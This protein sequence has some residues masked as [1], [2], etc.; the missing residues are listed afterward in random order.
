VT[1]EA[2]HRRTASGIAVPPFCADPVLDGQGTRRTVEQSAPGQYPFTRGIEPSLYGDGSWVMG[3]YSGYSSPRETNARIKRLVSAGQRGFSVALDLPT[4]L[5]LDSDDPRARGE[6]GRVGV[7]I[8]SLADMDE[9]LAGIPLEQI[10]QIRTTANAIGPIAVALFI[11][12]AEGRGV[13]PAS[14]RLLLQNDSLKE[15]VARGTYIFPPGPSLRFSVD[16]IEYCAKTL[17]SW[18]PIEFCGYHI[19]DTGSTAVQEVAVALSNARG[20]LDEAGRRGV[21]M[22]TLA[23]HLYMFL[24]AG[25]DI[26]EEIAKF[27]AARRVWARMLHTEYGVPASACGLRIFCYTL[28]SALTATEPRN[29]VVRVAYEALAAALGG[30]QTLAT[31]SYDEALGLPSEDAVHLS[32]RTQ[33]ILAYET[34]VCRVTDPLGGSHYVEWLTDELDAQVTSYME[35]IAQRGG[36]LGILES[37]WLANELTQASYQLQKET[38][39]GTRPL[40]GVNTLRS[41]HQEPGDE[42]SAF[43]LRG[44]DAAQEQVARLLRLR[45]ERDNARVDRALAEL[46][47]DAQAGANTVPKVLDA[48]RAYATVGEICATLKSIWGEGTTWA[49]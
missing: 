35:A 9:L 46:R 37:G 18:E 10:A 48:I 14:F 21:D 36:C 13:D 8:D 25:M 28:G 31:S 40:V 16:V 2:G 1:T 19:R 6:V 22:V 38:D 27:R 7:P 26:F 39:D 20:Y 32:L 12:A 5:G 47:T 42:V 17:P 49:L 23:P 30:V 15:Y 11:A 4:Q 45:R 33:Q 34:G 29:N 24:S 44:E 41:V 43:S 3:Q